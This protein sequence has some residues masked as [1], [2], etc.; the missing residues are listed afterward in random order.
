MTGFSSGD[1][2]LQDLEAGPSKDNN[3]LNT[4]LD[5]DAGSSDPFDIDQTKNA[6]PKTLKRWR[7][8]LFLTF[9]LISLSV[10]SS[11]CNWIEKE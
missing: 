7:V 9:F 3:D 10:C 8:I 5:P 4:N 11:H 1:D 6:T 2:G